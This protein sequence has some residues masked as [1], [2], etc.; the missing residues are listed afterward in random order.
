MAGLAPWMSVNHTSKLTS[1]KLRARGVWPQRLVGF[2]GAMAFGNM[3]RGAPN[4]G[5]AH[6]TRYIDRPRWMDVPPI[7][8]YGVQL[9]A[10]GVRSQYRKAQP[11][12]KTYALALS[13]RNSAQAIAAKRG[14]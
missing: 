1:V 6:I 11:A 9:P 2:N 7:F 3:R 8:V 10:A 13:L 4:A 14:A 12:K 5:W